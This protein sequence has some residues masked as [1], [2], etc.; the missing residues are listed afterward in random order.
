M[1]KYIIVIKDID[2]IILEEETADVQDKI[3]LT[4][5]KERCMFE[6]SK[7]I[8][9]VIDKFQ[10]EI[11]FEYK[12]KYCDKRITTDSQGNWSHLY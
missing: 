12:C 8:Q 1:G 2:L 7:A 11:N 9:P 10:I 4:N 3:M 5:I 6:V